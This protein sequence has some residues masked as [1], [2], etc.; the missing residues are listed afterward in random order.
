[1]GILWAL[2]GCLGLILVVY[3]P[4]LELS[5]ARIILGQ[6]IVYELHL[7]SFLTVVTAH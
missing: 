5:I 2:I 3:K 4:T 7:C 1:M 6:E